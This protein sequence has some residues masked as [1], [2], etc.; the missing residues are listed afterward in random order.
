MTDAALGLSLV[1]GI[2]GLCLGS[3]ATCAG[4]RLAED[5]SV[6]TPARSYCPACGHTLSWR[7]NIPLLG[8]LLLGGKCR[9]CAAAIPASYPLTELASGLF[10]AAAAVAF[11]PTLHLVAA[12]L[13]ATL[14]LVLSLIDFKTCLLPD[15][16]TLPGAA[17]AFACSC[18]LPPLWTLGIGW[19]S[20]L[21]G[22]LAGGGGL[23]LIAELYRRIR[24]VDG[25]GLGDAKL[26]LLVGALL[27]PAAVGVTLFL[28][29]CLAL[30]AGIAAMRRAEAAG[31]D[32]GLQTRLPFG[33]FLCA[34]AL[35]HLLA[36]PWLFHLWLGVPLP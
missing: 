22:G 16:L 12:L 19:K 33:P 21:L 28:G 25:L 20:A 34:G 1:S 36:G 10:A 27:G 23:W 24:G 15:A 9:H 6:L 30:P 31:E 8:W 32:T 17:A 35:L 29:A 11:G 5:G 13:F 3:F 2:A 7:E 14:C 18:L 26:M 4:H